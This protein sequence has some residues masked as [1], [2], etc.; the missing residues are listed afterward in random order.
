MNARRQRR[1]TGQPQRAAGVRRR[2]STTRTAC[3]TTWPCR[4]V[5]ENTEADATDDA[6]A[7]DSETGDNVGG[8]VTATDTKAD[9][10]PETLTYTLG[11][12]DAA[13]FRVQNN[14]QIEV[15]RRHGCWTTRPR[16]PTWSRSWPEDPLGESASIPVTIMVT[17]VDEMPEIMEGGLAISAGAITSNTRRTA[18][19]CSGDLYG[20]GPES[21]SAS[22]SPLS[23]DRRK[24]LLHQ[25]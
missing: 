1:G 13:M 20:Y 16:T 25:P 9:G 3:R 8:A 12:A 4:K 21:A 11:G 23:G 10:T 2:G 5:E 19:C 7:S 18:Q 24:C 15:A 17:D 6:D 22:W 14:G